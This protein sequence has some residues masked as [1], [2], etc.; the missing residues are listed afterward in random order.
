VL[1]IDGDALLRPR[2]GWERRQIGRADLQ[3]RVRSYRGGYLPQERRA[4]EQSLFNGELLGVTATTALELGVDVGDMNA[5]LH[6]GFPGSIASMWQQAGRAGRSGN[7]CVSV[8]IGT[9]SGLDQVLLHAVI[10]VTAG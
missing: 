8:I 4:I 5:T 2:C 9:T 7:A 1:P 10:A 3:S 6:V